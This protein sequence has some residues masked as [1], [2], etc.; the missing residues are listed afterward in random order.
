MSTI[1]ALGDR[2]L[3]LNSPRM[4]GRD[5]SSLQAKLNAFGFDCGEVDGV[6]GS[7]TEL[8][9]KAFQSHM[10]LVVDGIAGSETIKAIKNYS[11]KLPEGSEPIKELFN[12]FCKDIENLESYKSLKK[13]LGAE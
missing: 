1:Y 6:Y 4:N 11:T 3:K 8:A 7:K 10:R 13:L 9:V 5:V 12:Q 2:V